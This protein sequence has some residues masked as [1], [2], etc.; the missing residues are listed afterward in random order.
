[1]MAIMYVLTDMYSQYLEQHFP[2]QTPIS[3][4]QLASKSQSEE[5]KT[6]CAERSVFT[7]ARSR[8]I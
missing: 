7:R 2:S 4:D 8:G 3:S 6:R 5:E 1:M